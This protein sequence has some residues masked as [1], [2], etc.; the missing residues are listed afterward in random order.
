MPLPSHIAESFHRQAEA[1]LMLGSPFTALVCRLLADR[2]EPDSLFASRI[3]GWRGD[4]KDD[5]LPLRAAGALHAVAR[6]GRCPALTAAY[7]PNA[8]DP[9]TVWAGIV[10][11]I[12][13]EDAFLSATLDGPP[14]TNEVSRSNAILGG[15]L[16]IAEKTGTPLELFEI[17]ASAGLNLA[18]DRYGY[19][20]G[21]GRWGTV[22]APVQIAS[23]WEGDPPSLTTP[24]TIAARS[25][26][27]VKP[28]DPGSPADRDRLLSYIWADQFERLAR[29]E[30]ALSLAA[31]SGIRVERADA[32][33]WLE[34]RLATRR[35]SRTGR[36]SSSTRPSGA[37]STPARKT[38]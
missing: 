22:D 30:A 5:A 13:A 4:P 6:S 9:D 33:D 27:D 23:R 14:Q 16:F 7:P 2:L 35:R 20:L 19:D 31:Q 12:E 29:I 10:A 11:A 1:C 25:G 36:A 32:A 21:V 8:A 18:F 34:K 17:G 24:L 26:C 37:T 15:C 38:G 3:A 28:I